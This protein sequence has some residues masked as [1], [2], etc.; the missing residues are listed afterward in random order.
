V[1]TPT[2]HD[3]A[4]I[5]LL[6][7]LSDQVR[8]ALAA[9]FEVEVFAAGTDIVTQGRAGYAFY[10]LADGQVSVSQDGRELR[11]LSVGDFFGEIA[12]LGDGRRTATVTAVT[13]AVTWVLFGTVFRALQVGRPDVAQ[14]LQ[15]AMLDRLGS[16]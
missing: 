2:A 1:S 16:A 7:D 14:A 13:P 11:V 9:S 6:A 5:P 12:I 4:K 3:L 8:E 15:Q 10:V